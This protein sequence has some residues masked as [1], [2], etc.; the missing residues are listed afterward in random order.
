LKPEKSEASNAATF[1]GTSSRLINVNG[2][3][4]ARGRFALSLAF[5]SPRAARGLDAQS[6]S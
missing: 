4:S 6:G 2:G 3:A 5:S 1:A